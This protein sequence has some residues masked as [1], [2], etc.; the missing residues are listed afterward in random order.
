MELIAIGDL[1][2]DFYKFKRILEEF[3]VIEI[4]EN[5]PND[6]NSIGINPKELNNKVIVFIGDYVDWREEEL[7]NPLNLS[8]SLLIKGTA[9]ILKTI[10]L[11]DKSLKSYNNF[12]F[13]VGNH[14]DM[15]FKALDFII[16]YY[17]KDEF[18]QDIK[19]SEKLNNLIEIVSENPYKLIYESENLIFSEKYFNFLNWYFQGGKNTILSFGGIND[20]VSNILELSFLKELIL[21]LKIYDEENNVIFFSHTFPDDLEVLKKAIGDLMYIDDYIVSQFLW[22]RKIWGIDAFNGK[23]VEPTSLKEIEEIFEN[24]KIKYFV[25]GHTKVSKDINPTYYFNDKVINIDLH[26]TPLSNPLVI[27][28][29]NISKTLTIKYPNLNFNTG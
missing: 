13:L 7:E 8:K 29:L 27:K 26:G 28:N 10:E 11:I 24:N 23:Y 18:N 21:C 1:H 2:G 15:M 14:E 9:K 5:D 4:I 6:I 3:N 20:F 25:I 12:Y 22:S 16:N 19:N 17:L